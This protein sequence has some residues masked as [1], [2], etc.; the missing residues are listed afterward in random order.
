MRRARAWKLAAGALLALGLWQ[1]GL[2]L[3]IPAKA[4]AAQFLLHAAW[5]RTTAGDAATRPWPWADFRPL[6]ELE[7][8]G[9]RYVVVSDAAGESLAFAPA[10][11]A[12]SAEPGKPGVSVIA[13]H[14]DTHFA[15]I[16]GLELGD[17][18]S[19]NGRDGQRATYLVVDAGV[20]EHPKLTMP[21]DGVNR[22]VLVT[23]WPLRSLD[24]HPTKRYVVVAEQVR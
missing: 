11:V 4:A 24:P 6:A 10:H 16:D 21:G 20:L 3:W 14:R 23:C 2:G 9:R 12:G 8:A 5:S 17:A 7:V 18:L 13:A 22:L 15:G 19:V 1:V